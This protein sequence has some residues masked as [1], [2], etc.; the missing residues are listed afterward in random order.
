MG[1]KSKIFIKPSGVVTPTQV[2]FT[3]LCEFPLCRLLVKMHNLFEKLSFGT[4]LA[5]V[6]Y[7]TLLQLAHELHQLPLH[8][9]ATQLYGRQRWQSPAHIRR[10]RH[11]HA[12]PAGSDRGVRNGPDVHKRSVMGVPSSHSRAARAAALPAGE[13]LLRNQSALRPAAALASG[14]ILVESPV[15]PALVRVIG[16]VKETGLSRASGPLCSPA[17]AQPLTALVASM[18]SLRWKRWRQCWRRCRRAQCL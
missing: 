5:L 9:H 14:S 3:I 10:N 6:A 18:T 11:N 16:G 17:S 12:P 8:Y 15:P 13:G 2:K 4:Q 1:A 7:T